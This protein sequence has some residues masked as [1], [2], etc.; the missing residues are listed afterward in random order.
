MQFL[1]N[2]FRNWHKS[3]VIHMNINWNLSW[4]MSIVNIKWHWI[5]PDVYSISFPVEPVVTS[6][7][8]FS[9]DCRRTEPNQNYWFFINIHIPDSGR[10]MHTVMNVYIGNLALADVII[11]LFCIPFQFQAALLNRW[12]LPAFMCKLC[13]FLQVSIL[14]ENCWIWGNLWVFKGP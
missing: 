9:V 5:C 2:V 3:S 1:I 10:R 4:K 13:P 12:D 6:W 11:A 8:G 14:F 7:S